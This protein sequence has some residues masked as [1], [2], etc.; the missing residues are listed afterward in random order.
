MRLEG[1]EFLLYNKLMVGK[2][3]GGKNLRIL[4]SFYRV[5]SNAISRHREY[6][7]M[8]S[9]SLDLLNVRV[10]KDIQ[11]ECGS[12]A[13][14][15][16]E[17]L[18]LIITHYSWNIPPASLSSNPGSSERC[19]PYLLPSGEGCYYRSEKRKMS[20]CSFYKFRNSFESPSRKNRLR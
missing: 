20:P 10:F 11:A 8:V 17:M 4:R 6:R 18:L 16:C 14:Y 5:D 7:T 3:V 9:S 1:E 19:F 13:Q 15:Y 2:G 12:C